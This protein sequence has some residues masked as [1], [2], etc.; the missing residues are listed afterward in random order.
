MKS[1]LSYTGSEVEVC[2]ICYFIMFGYQNDKELSFVKNYI[3][4]SVLT[5]NEESGLTGCSKLPVGI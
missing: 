1:D 5:E 2:D 4:Y 3:A